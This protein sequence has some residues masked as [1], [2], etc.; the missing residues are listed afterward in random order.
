MTQVYRYLHKIAEPYYQ[1]KTDDRSFDEQ[2]DSAHWHSLASLC[3]F[4]LPAPVLA[5]ESRMSRSLF[6]ALAR[7]R[8]FIASGP[9][10]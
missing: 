1:A 8:Q 5:E 2:K 4:H 7:C 9:P 10:N 6:L 3:H